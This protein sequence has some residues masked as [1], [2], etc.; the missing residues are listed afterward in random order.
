MG[1]C[2]TVI[3]VGPFTPEVAQ[4]LEYSPE[5]YAGTRPGAIVV[6]QL[7]DC[8]F[9]GSNISRGFA[10]CLGITNAMD[11]NQH[12]LRRSAVDLPKLREYLATISHGDE[13]LKDAD[14]LERMLDLGW[15]LIFMP[16]G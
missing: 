2:A 16:N 1:M 7:F 3:C 6:S 5:Y 4:Y 11:F 8:C 12:V 9:M 13:Y 14:A 10:E 15:L